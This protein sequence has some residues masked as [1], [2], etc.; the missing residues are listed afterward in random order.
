MCIDAEDDGIYEDVLDKKKMENDEKIHFN[1][2]RSVSSGRLN[3]VITSEDNSEKTDVVCN[4]SE[5]RFLINYFI[6]KSN[7]NFPCKAHFCVI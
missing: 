7:N 5:L 1:R 2:L 3:S 4:Y 6:I